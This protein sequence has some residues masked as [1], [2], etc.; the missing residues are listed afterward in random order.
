MGGNYIPRKNEDFHKWLDHFTRYVGAK[1]LGA[2]P[3]WAHI[4]ADKTDEL[5][6]QSDAWCAARLAADETPTASNRHERD[7]VRKVVEAFVRGFI[8]DYLHRDPVTDEEREEAGVPNHGGHHVA[9]PDP[10][11]HVAFTLRIDAKNHTLWADYHIEG[12][13]SRGKGGYHGVEVRR[14]LLPLDA[15][16]PASADHPGWISEVDTGTPWGHTYAEG[17]IGMRAYIAMRWENESVG[18]GKKKGE[19]SGKG[20]WSSIVG[21]VVA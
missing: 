4:P 5:F 19:D 15:P 7:R 6:A 14:W 2:N 8:A 9:K 10:T 20:P 12:S 3:A 17:E 18:K 21:L 11:D 13:K 16:M 1:C